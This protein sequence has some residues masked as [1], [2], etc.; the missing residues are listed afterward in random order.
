MLFSESKPSHDKVVACYVS[1]WATYRQGHGTFNIEDIDPTL[2]TNL[3]YAFAGLNSTSSTIR[4]L[5]PYNDLDENY[6]KGK[7]LLQSS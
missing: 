1:T 4:S 6:G 3:I 2:C 7:W 5:D